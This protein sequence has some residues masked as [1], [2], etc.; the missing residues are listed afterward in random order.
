MFL[1]KGNL[2]MKRFVITLLAVATFTTG[3]IAADFPL[4]EKYPNVQPISTLEL[5]N[6]YSNALIV[7]VRSD[8]EFNVIHIGKAVH[9]PITEGSFL[10]TLEKLRPKQGAQPITFYCNG[11]TCAKSYKAAQEATEAGFKN[12]FCYDAGIP[13]WVEKHP[14]KTALMGKMPAAKEKLISAAMLKQ[15]MIPYSEFAR[16]SA[17]SGA[18]VIDVREPFQRAKNPELPQNRLLKLSGVREIALDR[19]VPMLAEKKFQDKELLITDAVGK[20]VQWLQYYLEDNG[21]SRYAFL[22][23]GVLAAADA[24]A[25]K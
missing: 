6:T 24:G 11:I 8:I 22:D 23:K 1:E 18:M 7:D 2:I 4:R 25:V 5:D 20:Q 21:Y 14:E 15:H 9:I 13:E 10:A 3:A 12:L 19:L 17:L 16:R